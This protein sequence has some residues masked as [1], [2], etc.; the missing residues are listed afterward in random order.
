MGRQQ[1]NGRGLKFGRKKE[2]KIDECTNVRRIAQNTSR[3]IHFPQNAR[4]STHFGD[5]LGT[6]AT[7]EATATECG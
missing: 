5:A 1:E 2:E 3:L 7:A 6:T 4:S